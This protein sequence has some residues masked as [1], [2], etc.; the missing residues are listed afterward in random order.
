MRARVWGA[1]G[2]LATPGA[3]SVLYGGN[4]SCVE[5]EL[6]DGTLVVLDAGTGIRQLGLRL[7]GAPPRK[8]HLLLTHLHL[9]HLEGLPF[10][11]P[12]WDEEFEIDIWGPPSA[13]TSLPARIGRYLSPPLFP[14]S[15]SDVRARLRF[16]DVPEGEWSLGPARVTAAAVIHPGPTVGY[17]IEENGRSLSYLPDHEPAL[18]GFDPV[19]PDW[20][21]GYELAER[22]NVLLHDCQY[23]EAEY[24][25]RVGWGHST[26]DHAVAFARVA[27]VER[28]VLFHHDPLHS[29][30][31]LVRLEERARDLWGQDGQ[32]P[33]LAYEGMEIVP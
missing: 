27:D 23:V 24:A 22:S 1:R 12:L 33:E 3:T 21:S 13:I 32:A 25:E 29:D 28:L 2:S 11:G 19:S 9:D 6:S 10:F 26:V 7:T 18:C 4:T 20:V 8:V 30:G 16:H 14:R 17:R 15:L 31:D 5:V